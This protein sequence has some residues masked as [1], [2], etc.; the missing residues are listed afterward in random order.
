MKHYDQKKRCIDF[1]KNDKNMRRDYSG[2]IR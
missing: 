1:D 2:V